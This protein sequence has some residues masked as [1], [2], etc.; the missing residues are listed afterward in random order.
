MCGKCRE[1]EKPRKCVYYT[2]IYAIRKCPHY[3][4]T[5]Q[6][7]FVSKNIHKLSCP[8]KIQQIL[9][10]F[11]K[12]CFSIM[13]F[14]PEVNIEMS[15]MMARDSHYQCLNLDASPEFTTDSYFP[16]HS[17]DPCQFFFF[18]KDQRLSFH[19]HFE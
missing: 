12:E 18:F 9:I 5:S 4:P 15:F 17:T 6:L 3:L 10:F 2:K 13:L 7:I 16:S 19:V 8:S 1:R 11:F 14:Y